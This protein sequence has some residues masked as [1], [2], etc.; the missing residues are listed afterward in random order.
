M[1]RKILV[2]VDM[3][4]DF[5]TGALGNDRCD[6]AADRVAELMENV[7]YDEIFVT[8]DCHGEDYP[9]TNEGR[10]LPVPH[11]I[12]GTAGYELDD[13]IKK[14]INAVRTHKNVRIRD[15]EKT[16]FGSLELGLL[17]K[18]ELEN[19]SGTQIDF[20]GICTGICVISNVLLAKAAVPETT[21]RVIADACACVTPESHRTALDAMKMCHIEVVE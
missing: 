1:N 13:R 16:T 3:Q 12:K 20:C 10:H 5:I 19:D 21:I 11:C 14:A 15:F 6:K 2:V 7:D 8:H 4:N 9:K 17:L 18:N